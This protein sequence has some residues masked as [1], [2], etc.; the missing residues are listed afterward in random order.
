MGAELLAGWVVAR[1]AV[2][3]DDRIGHIDTIIDIQIIRRLEAT[4]S[5]IISRIISLKLTL[6]PTEGV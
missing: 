3:M 5:I 6:M 4:A 2:G 1:L